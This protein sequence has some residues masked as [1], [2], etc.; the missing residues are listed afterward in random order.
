M[1]KDIEYRFLTHAGFRKFISCLIDGFVVYGTIKKDGFPAFG[2]ITDS[3]DLVLAR[4]PTH[5]SAK[6]FFFPQREALLEFDMASGSHSPIV[7]SRDQVVIGAHP[8]D[9][10]GLG[11]MDR[12]FS[13]GSTDV[14]YLA[15]RERTLIIGADC[16]PD[17]YCFC[18]SLGT[19]TIDKGFDLFL[20]EIK[21]GLLV[22]I[23]SEKGEAILSKYTKPL[24]PK[25][26]HLRESAKALEKKKRSFKAR[27]S[28]P[29]EELP[30]IYAKSDAH[31]VWEKIGAICYG[32][33][34][35]NNVCPT[36]YCFDVKDEVTPDLSG[37]ERVRVWDGCTLEEFA[38]VAGDHN[39]RRSRA[40]RLRHRFNR[41]FRY[42]SDKFNSL[43]C[44]GC[45][46]C[47]RTCLV[48]INITEVTNELIR[49]ART[50][51]EYLGVPA[52]ARKG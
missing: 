44:V 2:P 21:S 13:T 15:R 12:V 16:M 51:D 28:A 8:C 48:K 29:K 38:K 14:N 30:G 17:D 50:E 47:S 49:D 11:L 9:L 5:L 7:E 37:G 42:L 3:K 10:A 24:P 40:D 23:G 35:C 31:P 26:V 43:F 46:R 19:E 27:L 22:S 4:T 25:D 1:D 41:K 34:S 32:C 39:F 33:G 18:E 6:E 36:C 20:T 45:G 52:A